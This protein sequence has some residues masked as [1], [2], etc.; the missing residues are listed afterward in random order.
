MD[1]RLICGLS[2]ETQKLLKVYYTVVKIKMI[3]KRWARS[4][5]RLPHNSQNVQSVGWRNQDIWLIQSLYNYFSRGLSWTWKRECG[6]RRLFYKAMLSGYDPDAKFKLSCVP[7]ANIQTKPRPEC[8]HVLYSHLANQ[9][10]RVIKM[11]AVHFGRLSRWGLDLHA[12][13]HA[14]TSFSERLVVGFNAS[15]NSD[16]QKLQNED[17][18]KLTRSL[19]VRYPFTENLVCP[20]SHLFPGR[21]VSEVMQ[22]YG[23]AKSD[24]FR[25][26]LSD[27]NLLRISCSW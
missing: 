25:F 18:F 23:C 9:K 2:W 3:D 7:N 12:H 1:S 15:N 10:V 16:I 26:R 19:L 5:D 27:L 21:K 11:S 4:K 17:I 8:K 6:K 13:L 24:F 14:F 20:V 22:Q